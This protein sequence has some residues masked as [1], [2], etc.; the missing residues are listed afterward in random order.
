MNYQGDFKKDL[1]EGEKAERYIVKQLLREYPTL[2]KVEGYNPGYDL[3]DEMGYTVEVKF[4]IGSK[5]T[6]NIAFE[7][8]Y[9]GNP[10]GIS[11]S[12]ALDWVQIY[13]SNGWVYSQMRT[14][15]LKIF[16]KSNIK[17]FKIVNGGDDNKSHLILVPVSTFQEFF[18]S[19][20]IEDTK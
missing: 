5:T 9:K 3:I 17:S 2:K 18:C 8:S 7:Y 10:S 15:N 11:T 20:R 4:D 1:E 12:S 16:L 19:K 6:G 13:F 14:Y